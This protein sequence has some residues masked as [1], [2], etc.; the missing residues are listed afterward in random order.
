MNAPWQTRS[1]SDAVDA[2]APDGSE[3]RFLAELAGASVVHCT[4]PPGRVTQAVEHRTV[5]EAWFFLEG[6]GKVWR[7]AADVEQITNVG[8]GMAITIPLGT[9]FQFRTTGAGPLTFVIASSPPWPGP[10]E[11]VPVAG[12]WQPVAQ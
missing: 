11:A 4:L 6:S 5:E 7:R 2:L 12:A 1:I 9:Q 3:I 8:S 10:D